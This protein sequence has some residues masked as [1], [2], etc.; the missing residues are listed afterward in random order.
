M[1]HFV[2][3]SQTLQCLV[4]ASSGRCRVASAGLRDALHCN[5][6]QELP[7]I[8]LAAGL[9]PSLSTTQY[10]DLVAQLRSGKQRVVRFW[11]TLRAG[12][13]SCAKM[14]N[15]NGTRARN[16]YVGQEELDASMGNCS[17]TD[18]TGTH[19]EPLR[20][21]DSRGG[22]PTAPSL[23]EA[24]AQLQVMVEMELCRV[25]PARGAVGACNGVA[26]LKLERCLVLVHFS[27]VPD[28]AE[29]DRVA[30][31]EAQ[32]LAL[33]EH[34]TYMMDLLPGVACT[35]D[36]QGCYT[37]V[38]RAMCEQL[39]Q[40]REALL[41]R[42]FAEV[43]GGTQD[44]ELVE[45]LKRDDHVVLETGQP[46]DVPDLFLQPT[47]SQGGRWFRHVKKPY[48]T[49]DGQQ[50][51][52]G[53]ATDITE[54]KELLL[55][56]QIAEEEAL[57]KQRLQLMVDNINV[58]AIQVDRSGD[59]ADPRVFINSAM[60][61]LVGYSQEEVPTLFAWF[62]LLHQ[63][64]DGSQL[65][66]YQERMRLLRDSSITTPPVRLTELY[67]KDGS[68]RLFECGGG[69]HPQGEVWVIHDITERHSATEKF[70]TI[71]NIAT[72][73]YLVFSDSW[74]LEC[75][76]AA[77]EYLGYESKTDVVGRYILEFSPEFQSDGQRS[78]DK[79][80]ARLKAT[81]ETGKVERFE[82]DHIR[83]DGVPLPTEVSIKALS[84]E[85]RQVFIAI[86]HDLR[87]RKAAEAALRAAKEEA[88]AAYAAK[89]QFLS[90]C[91]HEIRTPMNG[92]I[93]V[94][95]LLLDTPLSAEQRGFVETIRGSGDHL[96]KLIND[97]LDLAKIEGRNLQLETLPFG[98]RGEVHQTLALLDRGARDKGLALGVH[99]SDDVPNEVV[100]D[101]MRLRQI[102]L[103]LLSNAL[104]FTD[105]GGIQVAVRLVGEGAA[106][107]ESSNQAEGGS[108]GLKLERQKSDAARRSGGVANGVGTSRPLGEA[109]PEEAGV[110]LQFEVRDTGV[111]IPEEAQERIFKAF[112]QA[113]SS[114]SRRYGGTGLGLCISQSL[115]HAMGG[116]IWWR[117]A[118]D[119]GTSFFFTIRLGL[120]APRGG[121]EAQAPSAEAASASSGSAP[122]LADPSTV[123]G[124][125][126][127]L[128][129]LT[130]DTLR[131][132]HVL[133]AEDNTVNQMVAS[134]I[135]RSLG[136][137]FVVVDNG[138]K[139]VAACREGRFDVVLMD[140]HMPE[141]DGY[142][143]T[144]Q[145]R[146][147][148]LTHG[149]RHLI[150]A[151]TASALEDD[152][153]KCL[154]AGM[155]SFL[156]KPVRPNDVRAAIEGHL[157]TA[158]VDCLVSPTS[159]LTRRLD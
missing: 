10:A 22:A 93:G 3:Q 134:R 105:S 91:S 32:V 61:R 157:A 55:Q 26:G 13:F 54:L 113:D 18:S 149:R 148:E 64:H 19:T 115:V 77:V 76:A 92:V 43:V 110:A 9:L 87:E 136:C 78:A 103:N 123:A 2:G 99:V 44:A 59:A 154:R 1:E 40:P 14:G 46:L 5:G 70:E 79:A 31:L 47:N 131:S 139:A 114:T 27:P 100:G 141:L 101:P 107:V 16:G 122:L 11:S 132:L 6:A 7:E 42:S 156:S 121:P 137:E 37:M 130:K 30:Q 98:L 29:P 72:D 50:G 20:G 57:E 83:A 80:A 88:E 63:D 33:Q 28:R 24:A 53:F 60:E 151:L 159:P 51:V 96:L 12:G 95:E 152:A 21:D 117:S 45:T 116:R 49:V 104:K 74:F 15:L 89:S 153:Q 119:Q 128:R 150:I 145:I 118:V 129:I 94:A 73:P 69:T 109:G 140:C 120:P 124:S 112:M 108:R 135:L 52:F 127:P 138:R 86:W 106:G 144:R 38:N 56:A 36:A 133:V 41:G 90:N 67:R 35:K 17:L 62:R 58:S 158:K 65:A 66:A 84:L 23:A 68:K 97:I 75:N 155:D 102:L 8:A 4:D 147:D 142:E 39:G 85:G 125:L 48:T 71:F 82:W 81:K 143:A 146:I 25:A 126:S 111:G 34:Y